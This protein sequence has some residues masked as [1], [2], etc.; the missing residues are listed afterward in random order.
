MAYH[1]THAAC[2]NLDERRCAFDISTAYSETNGNFLKQEIA[3]ELSVDY[4]YRRF[5]QASHR[6]F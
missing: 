6:Y 2:L 3:L 5:P 4:T 1:K